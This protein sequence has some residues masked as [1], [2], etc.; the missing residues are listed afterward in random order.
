MWVESMQGSHTRRQFPVNVVSRPKE[1]VGRIFNEVFNDEG[2]Y[3]GRVSSHNKKA[4]FWKVQCTDG[5]IEEFNVADMVNYVVRGGMEPTQPASKKV[6]GHTATPP[7]EQRQEME[8]D[9]AQNPEVKPPST[10]AVAATGTGES[11]KG[12]M[13]KGE[14][15]PP[16]PVHFAKGP[17]GRRA[18][19]K[20]DRASTAATSCWDLQSQSST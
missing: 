6:H 18:M 15:K 13:K 2:T 1:F 17:P 3:P 14:S 7:A 11:R 20:G 10:P 19:K 16:R 12:A 4:G 5:G 9:R 8:A